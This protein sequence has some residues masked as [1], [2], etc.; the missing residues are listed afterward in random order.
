MNN[1][2]NFSLIDS[3]LLDFQKQISVTNKD[4]YVIYQLDNDNNVNELS[5]LLENPYIVNYIINR[6]Y[7]Q[8]FY[9]NTN[10]QGNPYTRENGLFVVPDKTWWLMITGFKYGAKKNSPRKLGLVAYDPYYQN[11]P[12]FIT[13]IFYDSFIFNSMMYH[14]LGFNINNIVMIENY[15]LQNNHNDYVP[16]NYI[17]EIVP[18][19]KK[20]PSKKKEDKRKASKK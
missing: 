17:K 5:E 3:Y 16:F 14:N 20:S 9:I 7:E 13:N 8:P 6:T 11:P 2:F 19:K 15:Y 4:Y 1:T 10:K 12:N 18:K